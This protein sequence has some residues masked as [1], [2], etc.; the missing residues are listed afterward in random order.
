M[1]QSINPDELTHLVVK[2]KVNLLCDPYLQNLLANNFAYGSESF[3]GSWGR[4][5]KEIN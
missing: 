2:L 1:D 4:S 3:T 5:C